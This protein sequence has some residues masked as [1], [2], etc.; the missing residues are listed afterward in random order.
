[1]KIC[2][3]GAGAVGGLVAARPAQAGHDVSVVARG[4]HLAAIQ[5][6]GLRILFEKKESQV[7]LRADSD[8]AALGPQDCVFV[9]V[10]GQ[11]L[12]EVAKKIGPMIGKDTSIVT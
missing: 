2:I 5:Q 9:A 7:K 11:G 3:Y 6:K 10:K 4:A 8:P 1:M 12:P